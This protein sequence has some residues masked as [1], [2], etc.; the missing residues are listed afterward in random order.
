MA[1]LQVDNNTSS[2]MTSSAEEETYKN[3][4]RLYNEGEKSII[5]EQLDQHQAT[6]TIGK[7]HTCDQCEKSFWVQGI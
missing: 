2:R 3:P 5:G 4:E 1:E 7:P 6:A